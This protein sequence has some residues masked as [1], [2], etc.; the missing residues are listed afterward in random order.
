[1]NL[2]IVEGPYVSPDDHVYVVE[3]RITHKTPNSHR[4]WHYLSRFVSDTMD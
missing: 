3:L 2:K 4:F 1:M